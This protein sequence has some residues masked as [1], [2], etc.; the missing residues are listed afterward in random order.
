MNNNNTSF[1]IRLS[2]KSSPPPKKSKRSNKTTSRKHKRSKTN[3]NGS[4]QQTNSSSTNSSNHIITITPSMTMID[5]MEIIYDL[6][7]VTNKQ[8]KEYEIE[9]YSGFP[10]KR[11]EIKK[12]Q[13]EGEV[14]VSSHIRSGENVIVKFSENTSCVDTNSA[15]ASSSSSINRTSTTTK[16][17]DNPTIGGR[18]K[19]AAASA[20][21]ASFKEVIKE[22]DKILRN[23]KTRATTNNRTKR[24]AA[25]NI[26]PNNEESNQQRSTKA[27]AARAAAANSRKLASLP[28]GRTLNSTSRSNNDSNNATQPKRLTTAPNIFKG[29]KSEEDI[30]FALLSSINTPGERSNSGKKISKVLRSAMKRTVEKS[31]EAS[32]AV[33][34]CSSIT[35][36]DITFIDSSSS[37]TTQAEGTCNNI[38]TYNVKYPKGIEG[39]G[40]YEDTNIHVISIETLKAVI[41]SVYNASKV[42][43][44][45]E[46]HGD[47]V[48]DDS[49]KEMLK[50]NNMALL[51][52]RVFWSLWYHYRSSCT[53]MEQTL[54][55]ILPELDWK[56]LY[57]RSRQ[58]SEKAKE[59]LRQKRRRTQGTENHITKKGDG[60][61]D[62]YKA[63]VNAVKDVEEAMEQMY[64]RNDGRDSL[65]SHAAEAALLRMQKKQNEQKPNRTWEFVNTPTEVDTDE[66]KECIVEAMEVVDTQWSTEQ[67]DLCVKYMVKSLSINNWR[68][69]ANANVKETEAKLKLYFPGVDDDFVG[70]IIS[71]AQQRSMEEIMLEIVNGNQDI[72]QILCEEASSVTPQDLTLWKMVPS[73][74]LEEVPS[75]VSECNVSEQIVVDWCHG[76]EVA[77]KT[78]EWLSE[79]STSI[80]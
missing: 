77:M 64:Q 67:I 51:S 65:R 21:T 38:G 41:R 52:P 16:L 17:D 47:D 11:I 9:L 23:E 44:D 24:K 31:Y 29:M 62:D 69:L 54:E 14:L 56:F 50:P 6:F 40:Y 1:K 79:F 8:Q 71:C 74:L 34:R 37:S 22:Q 68:M 32:R 4:S 25:S 15:S 61:V 10:P 12:E 76:A 19:R 5:L 72:Y 27:A 2:L 48:D 53:S 33:V 55:C 20:A 80:T 78:F 30:S 60:E 3:N 46:Q 63:S 73:V 13:S 45:D 18:P 42:E 58:L 26:H 36:G 7:D 57:K 39:I 28:G 35:S 49:G 66:L 59:N 43:S 75:L 70:S